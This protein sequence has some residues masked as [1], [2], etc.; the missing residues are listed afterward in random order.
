MSRRIVR[1]GVF[2]LILTGFVTTGAAGG[3]YLLE[4]RKETVARQ[5]MAAQEQQEREALARSF[6]TVL[7]GFIHDMAQKMTAYKKQ[8]RVLREIVRP[9]NFENPAYAKENYD[10]FAGQIAPA[11]RQSAIGVL[12]E[13]SK[14]EKRVKALLAEEP[15]EIRAPVM[16]QWNAMRDEQSAAY[17]AFFDDESEL[18]DAYADLL[19]FYAARTG[20]YEVDPKTGQVMFRRLQ[21]KE[22]EQGYIDAINAIR[23]RRKADVRS[24]GDGA[25]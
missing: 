20:Q 8:R 22:I 12:D 16:A 10:I 9:L 19:K 6:E 21:D 18:L 17:M 5:E 15:E 11:L 4:K 14:T 25:L 13:F 24:V 2:F 23:D 1:N 7:N 3:F